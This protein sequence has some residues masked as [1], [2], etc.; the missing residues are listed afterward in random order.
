M[1]YRV[2][3]N[4]Y[5]T[6]PEDGRVVEASAGYAAAEKWAKWYENSRCDYS[7]ASGNS[8]IVNVRPDA[9]GESE[10]YEVTGEAVPHYTALPMKANAALTG[11]WPEEST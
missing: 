2:W 3:C 8:V 1:K 7:I 4:E 9:G 6:G 10:Q 5:H 11:R